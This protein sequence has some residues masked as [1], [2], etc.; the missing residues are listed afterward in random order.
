MGND[1]L[2]ITETHDNGSFQKSPSFIPAEPAPQ[3]DRASGAA[4]LLSDCNARCVMDTNS[5]G[6]CIVYAPIRAAVC[7]IFAICIYVPHSKHVNP[8]RTDKLGDLDKLL[9]HISPA[10]NIVNMGDFNACLPSSHFRRKSEYQF[11]NDKSA[12]GHE[13]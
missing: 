2:A 4:L 9:S 3:N 6:S 11:E 7:N 13:N 12:N 5:I 10:D 1:I 8:S